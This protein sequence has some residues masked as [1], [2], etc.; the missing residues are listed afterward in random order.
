M[1][2]ILLSTHPEAQL[3]SSPHSV[4]RNLT[5]SPR[6]SPTHTLRFFFEQHSPHSVIRIRHPLLVGVTSHL[7]VGVDIVGHRP[8]PSPPRRNG[9]QRPGTAENQRDRLLRLPRSPRA[10]GVGSVRLD[11]STRRRPAAILFLIGNVS[12]PVSS[13]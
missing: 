6:I 2:S 1:L 12:P 9:L 4:I 10:T 11:C 3:H 8:I 7:L 5:S 13:L